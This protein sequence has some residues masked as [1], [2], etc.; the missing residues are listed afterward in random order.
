MNFI[1]YL[2]LKS[3]CN[4]INVSI[5][6]YTFIFKNT[7]IFKYLQYKVNELGFEKCVEL[8]NLLL[9]SLC[10]YRNIYGNI[11]R[12]STE[13]YFKD[14]YI[15]A[16]KNSNVDILNYIDNLKK[17]YNIWHSL[18]NTSDIEECIKIVLEKGKKA[19]WDENYLTELIRTFLSKNFHYHLMFNS[20]IRYIGFSK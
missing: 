20:C 15:L 13:P 12:L 14:S 19:G 6:T 1:I 18:Y 16:V 11:C 3:I 8:N 10:N 9:L 2:P 4:Y 5:F 7:Q 17:K